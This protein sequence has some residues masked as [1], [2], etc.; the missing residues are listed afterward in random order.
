MNPYNI[1]KIIT[2]NISGV[3]VIEIAIDRMHLR[4][5]GLVKKKFPKKKKK[6]YNNYNKILN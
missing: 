1:S 3:I 2:V 6:E 4:M 5:D